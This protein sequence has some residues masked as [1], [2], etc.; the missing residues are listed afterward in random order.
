[1]RGAGGRSLPDD[2]EALG[3]YGLPHPHPDEVGAGREQRSVQTGQLA[4][5][6]YFVRMRMGE[7]VQTERLTV[8]R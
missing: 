2:G 8:V 6:T 3:L 1:M 4:P 7:T 5:G